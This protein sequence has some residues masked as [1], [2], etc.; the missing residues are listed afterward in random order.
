MRNPN[1]ITSRYHDGQHSCFHTTLIGEVMDKNL[2]VAFGRGVF[3]LLHQY[4]KV[5]PTAYGLTNGL[6]Y[7]RDLPLNLADLFHR[8][9]PF[10]LRAY[11]DECERTVKTPMI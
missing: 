2:Q 9:F 5:P 7:L 8:G 6:I 10:A 3:R 11:R 1:L 4:P